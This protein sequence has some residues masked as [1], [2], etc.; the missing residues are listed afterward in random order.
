MNEKDDVGRNRNSEQVAQ[1]LHFPV[2][3][4]RR[5]GLVHGAEQADGGQPAM[6]ELGT[7]R[8]ELDVPVAPVD[9]LVLQNNCIHR[10]EN[11]DANLLV[12]NVNVRQVVNRI[13]R[14]RRPIH[15]KLFRQAL[16][17]LVLAARKTLEKD[18]DLI[19]LEIR[20]EFHELGLV[21]VVQLD[22]IRC[23]ACTDFM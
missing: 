1:Q 15:N 19:G 5:D 10:L 18:A 16:E 2:L 4:G 12:L 3:S 9:T 17:D 6:L 21:I 14:A 22:K 8:A 11:A 20:S 7:K 23:E 13:Y